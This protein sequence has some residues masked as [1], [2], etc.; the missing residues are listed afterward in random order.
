MQASRVQRKI[1]AIVKT[2]AVGYSTGAGKSCFTQWW[3]SK[4]E[5]KSRGSRGEKSN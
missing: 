3:K 5:A 1:Y 2:N 4:V